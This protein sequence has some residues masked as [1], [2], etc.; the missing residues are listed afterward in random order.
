MIN[1]YSLKTTRQPI[2]VR[3]KTDFSKTILMSYNI[4]SSGSCKFSRVMFIIYVFPRLSVRG[5]NNNCLK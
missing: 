5:R 1:I 2:T 4:G 3:P